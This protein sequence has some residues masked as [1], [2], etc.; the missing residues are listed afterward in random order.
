MKN[1]INDIIDHRLDAKDLAENVGKIASSKASVES[2]KNNH[3]IG[4]VIRGDVLSIGPC[5]V[6]RIQQ[7]LEHEHTILAPVREE[8][9]QLT[10]S[11]DRERSDVWKSAGLFAIAASIAIVAV[12]TLTPD[13][14]GTVSQVEQIAQ[15]E[16][17]S[18]KPAGL[19]EQGS[20]AQQGD[21]SQ[22]FDAEF[23]QMLVEH[24][25]F[26]ATSGLNGLVAYAKLVSNET[27][28]E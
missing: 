21:G 15:V 11:T 5:L 1:T 13:I 16:Q 19:I 12:L 25:E 7:S 8:S 3:L 17:T 18:V 20:P 22:S 28:G 24:G 9:L 2:W 26:S 14:S 27:L 6:D 4:D 10:G 23:G